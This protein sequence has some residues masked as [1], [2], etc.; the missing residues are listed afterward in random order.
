MSGG[1]RL[2][3]LDAYPA[4]GRQALRDV[5]ATAAGAL[6][7]RV[8]RSC[9]PGARVDIATPADPDFTL[10]AGVSLGDYDGIVWTGSSLTIHHARDARVLRQV[11]LARAAYRARVPSFGSCWAAQLAVVAAG[12]ACAPNPRGREFG[13]ARKITLTPAG[14][15]HLLF[16]GRSSAFDALTSHEDEVTTLPAGAELLA[17]NAFSRV[18]AVAIEHEGGSFWALQYHPEY[19]LHEVA[20]L[21]ALRA[22]GL[23]AQGDFHDRAA[24]DRFIAQLEALHLE[25]ARRDL[26][27]RLA[28]DADVLDPHTRQAEVRHWLEHAVHPAAGR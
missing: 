7:E 15:E 5:G 8:L 23:I 16:A 13:L 2:L 17:S 10:P 24:A 9:A 26:A 19:D 25:P 28:V 12:G 4:D 1:L 11:E 27:Y 20:R 18:Q 21:A 14:R 22:E 3:V 6:Y